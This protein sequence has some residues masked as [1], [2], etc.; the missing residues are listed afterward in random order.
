MINIYYYSQ[1][2]YTDSNTNN[3]KE[4]FTIS[5]DKY[6]E[7]AVSQKTG[8]YIINFLVDILKTP[9]KK[10]NIHQILNESSSFA[11]IKFEKNKILKLGNVSFFSHFLNN[12]NESLN[13]IS[14]LI[15]IMIKSLEK[16]INLL[17]IELFLEFIFRTKNPYISYQIFFYFLFVFGK[18]EILNKIYNEYKFHEKY[19]HYSSVY[20]IVFD[21][22]INDSFNYRNNIYDIIK[23][24]D[25]FNFGTKL[26][27]LLEK[28][29]ENCLLKVRK[30]LND[31]IFDF[32]INSDD[33]VFFGIKRNRYDDLLVLL[34]YL[35]SK[36]LTISENLFLEILSEKEIDHKIKKFLIQREIGI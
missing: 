19:F 34:E 15:E 21:M 27:F 10:Y 26:S 7:E 33:I 5:K 11:N 1:N 12:D 17:N 24:L 28:K 6:L 2:I 18:W 14:D 22:I 16:K 20:E 25:T 13:I 8:I 9:V 35:Y 32:N 36:N 23:I 29:S 30:F 31:E 3:T 4:N